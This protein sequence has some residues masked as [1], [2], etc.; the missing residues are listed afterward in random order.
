MVVSLDEKDSGME[1]TISSTPRSF[2]PQ[3][4]SA[5]KDM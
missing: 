1:I 2:S 3:V 5:E 4:L